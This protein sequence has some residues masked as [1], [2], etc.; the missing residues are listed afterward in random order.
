MKRKKHPDP[1]T[2]FSE[3]IEVR[4]E[5]LKDLGRLQRKID[6]L[7]KLVDANLY[8]DDDVTPQNDSVN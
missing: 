3:L 5:L 2:E 4:H 6:K 8:R 7:E 1:E